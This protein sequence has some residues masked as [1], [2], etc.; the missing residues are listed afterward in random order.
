MTNYKN[1]STPEEKRILFARKEQWTLSSKD[2]FAKEKQKALYI[3]AFWERL[4]KIQRVSIQSES[5]V[6]GFGEVMVEAKPNTILFTE[7]GQ[8][9]V[10][11]GQELDFSNVLR[12][13]LDRSSQMIALEHLRHGPKRP[14]FLFH[15][16]PTGPK[17][18]QSV[19]S[20]LCRD[21]CYFGRIEVLDRH[22][23]FLWRILGPRKNET[24]YH[25]YE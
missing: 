2:H 22:I 3:G 12:W 18:L 14:V 25:T 5:G 10:P 8:W 11:H 17:G 13:T 16:A 7:K 15:L 24:L 1:Q 20:H 21:D 19:D 6:Q 4:S 23:R 9:M